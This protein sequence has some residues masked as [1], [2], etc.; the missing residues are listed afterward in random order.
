MLVQFQPD[1]ER[2]DGGGSA[3]IYAVNDQVVL[4]SPVTYVL[5][6]DESWLDQ[7]EYALDTVCYH[8]DIQNERAILRHLQ[9]VPHANIVQAIALEHPE[10]IYLRRY[11]PL[12]RRLKTEKPAQSIRFSWYRD[13]LCALVHLHKLEIA[14]AD[15]RL[16]NFLCHSKDTIVLCDF[17]CSRRFGQE[18][19]SA[20]GSSRTLGVNG[21]SQVVSDITDRFALASVMFEIETGTRP[22]LTVLDNT[23]QIPAIKTGSK[24]LDLIIE[25]AWCEKYDSTIDMLR[26]IEALLGF[27]SFAAA[28]VL[29]TA[30]IESLQTEITNWRRSRARKHGSIILLKEFYFTLA[31]TFTQVKSY[32]ACVL[33]NESKF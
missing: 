10:G 13:M 25:R 27:S 32:T 9:R 26:D 22:N 23:T 11:C 30:A 17:T 3:Y 8:D 20:T 28:S 15:I 19:P 16:D 4:K 33:R 6:R 18:N 24:S 2:L 12:S 31:D 1:L 14:H 5:P 29:H 21:S 7:Y